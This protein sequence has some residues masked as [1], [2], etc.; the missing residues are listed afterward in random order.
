MFKV[1]VKK[2]AISLDSIEVIASGSVNVYQVAFTFDESWKPEYKKFAIFMIAGKVTT[3][4]LDEQNMCTIPWILTTKEFACHRLYCGVNGRLEDGS[5]IL[6]TIW[7]SLGKVLEGAEIEDN[8]PRPP[9]PS[10]YDELLDIAKKKGDSLNYKED[11]L[12]LLSGE[13]ILSTVNIKSADDLEY[14]TESEIRAL[15]DD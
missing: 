5:I 2:S 15:F 7:L 3:V 13:D 8:L 1:S 14:A 12:S 4:P 9:F 10:A 11:E 6:P